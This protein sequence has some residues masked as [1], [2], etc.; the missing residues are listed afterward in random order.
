M[1]LQLHYTN[2]PGVAAA[3]FIRGSNAVGWLQEIGRWQI[4]VSQ[5]EC[6]PI[7]ISAADPSPAGLFVIFSPNTKLPELRDPYRKIGKRLYIPVHAELF[8]AITDAELES[9]LVWHRQVFHPSSGF[10]GFEEK[11]RIDP[12]SFI[13][14]AAGNGLDWSFANPGNP[15]RPLIHE[16]RVVQVSA[17]E[18]IGAIME[19]LDTKKLEDI[20]KTEKDPG[21]MEKFFDKVK[22]GVF[23]FLLSLVGLVYKLAPK[24]ENGGQGLHRAARWLQ[25]SIGNLD[26]K[27]QDE[28]MRLLRLFEKDKDEALKYA[29]PLNSKYLNRGSGDVSA[30]L[31]RRDPFFNLGT[32]GGGQGVQFWNMDSHYHT[33]QQKYRQM[34]E[35]NSNTDPR[36]AAYIY[37]HLLGDFHSAASVLRKGK[38][39][40][41]AAALYRDHLDNKTEAASCLEEGGHLNEALQLFRELKKYEKSGDIS[42]LLG[43]RDAAMDYYEKAVD[44][45]L[46]IQSYHSA[47]LLLHGKKQETGRA[48]KVLMEGWQERQHPET[49]LKAWFDLSIREQGNDAATE[50]VYTFNQLDNQKRTPELL[51]VLSYVN[52]SYL[53]DQSGSPATAIAYRLVGREVAEGKLSMLRELKRFVEDPLI[54]KDIGRFLADQPAKT[55]KA[56]QPIELDPG[57]RWQTASWSVGQ[58]L[59]CGVKDKRVMIARV[60]WF[61]HVEYYSWPDPVEGRPTTR[62]ITNPASD[63][64][65]V[66]VNKTA[67]SERTMN[68][69][70]HFTKNY[71]VWS[72]PWIDTDRPQVWMHP[73]G[74]VTQLAEEKGR[75]V[76]KM[77]GD[78]GILQRTVIC[79]PA[80]DPIPSLHPMGPFITGHNRTIFA[81]AEKGLV[82]IGEHGDADYFPI[83]SRIRTCASSDGLSS[84]RMVI[85]TNTGCLYISLDETSNPLEGVEY[86]NRDL[87]PSVIAFIKAY[88][89]VMVQD[90]AVHVFE[91]V[92]GRPVPRKEIR[93]T[94]AVAAC[95]PT[96]DNR[97]FA[98]VQVDGTVLFADTD[99]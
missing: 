46:S 44:E 52:H 73:D 32:L 98:I 36:K 25:Q 8:P 34:A 93:A 38:F 70:K 12:G 79:R 26:K 64:A 11:D 37:A 3:A 51:E 6:F 24:S 78:D 41:E 88:T 65:I 19:E 72:P 47:A 5:L 62:L 57:V 49:C 18:T 91:V 95:L 2:Q 67:L 74:S 99:W 20:P 29:P 16:I 15:A 63:W 97:R 14:V 68:R 40:R 10:A 87:I 90:Q 59:V 66:S 71:E 82:R 31:S 60:N 1:I 21:A 42:S 55:G 54:G 23:R 7:A 27:R 92:D 17:D 35:E 81:C 45:Q 43:Q 22:M 28:L 94:A 89:F 58:F 96:N 30:G 85:S 77:F 39:Y 61:G 33:L 53:S 69:N 48:K 50:L 84:T 13:S 76:K 75:L 80:G 56:S 4:P 86:F 9:L 83:D